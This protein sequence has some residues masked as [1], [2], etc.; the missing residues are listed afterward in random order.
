M[1]VIA[2]L[3]AGAEVRV[4]PVVGAGGRA[5]AGS[6]RS[7]PGIQVVE[8]PR[9]ATLLVV[10]GRLTRA[11]LHPALVVHDQLPHPRATLWLPTG[12]DRSADPEDLLSA[13][14]AVTTI[15]GGDAAALRRV[16]SDVISGVR[17][18][19]PPALPDMEPAHWRGVGPYG[20][21]GAGM[22]GGVPYGRPLAARAPDPDGLEL[23]QLPL[24]LGPLHP[25][26]PPGL[27]LHVGLHGDVVRHAAVGANPYQSWP[28][29]PGPGPVDTT[30]FVDALR[31]P[32]PVADLELARARHHLR[33]ASEMLRLHGLGALG[34]RVSALAASL[35]LGDGGAVTSMARRLSRSRSLAWATSGVGVAA[36][37]LLDGL[38]PRLE[39]GP[40]RR[41]AGEDGDARS[42]DPA[43]DGL[44]FEPVVH[45]EADAWAR[46]RQRLAEAAQAMDLARRAGARRREPGGALEGP[47]GTLRLDHPMPST[48]LCDALPALVAGSEW[49]DVVTTV[50]SLDLDVEEAALPA[51]LSA[52]GGGIRDIPAAFGHQNGGGSASGPSS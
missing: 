47:R 10:V 35:T 41:A 3:A 33:W 36:T 52:S 40:V 46:L 6:L 51:P 44:G 24:Q 45:R 42:D 49:G 30:A 15:D 29:D 17:P 31:S 34:L 48:A 19:D 16:F 23:D 2:R 25:A 5:A 18:S 8:T 39:G 7:M 1:G 21:G 13:F 37:E 9:A 50:A 43:Y 38:E 22:T 12:S 14:P 11:L 4:F 20:H 26:L 28:G 27:V 32:T